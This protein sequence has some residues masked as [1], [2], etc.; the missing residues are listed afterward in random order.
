[1]TRIRG[2]RGSRIPSDG[3]ETEVA[4]TDTASPSIA[5]QQKTKKRNEER[6]KER[7]SPPNDGSLVRDLPQ[8]IKQPRNILPE[9][10]FAFLGIFMIMRAKVDDD[11]VRRESFVEVRKAP[12]QPCVCIRRETLRARSRHGRRKTLAGVLERQSSSNRTND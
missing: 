10:H 1:M 4:S 6:N 3:R 11:D 12:K 7:K 9:G 5:G 2:G 8:V